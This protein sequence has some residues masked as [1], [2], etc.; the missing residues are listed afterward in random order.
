MIASA[1]LFQSSLLNGFGK[2]VGFDTQLVGCF[3]ARASSSQQIFGLG[4]HV[5]RYHVR[6]AFTAWSIERFDAAFPVELDGAFD[7]IG[8]NA[9]GFDNFTLP[10][11]TLLNELSRKPSKCRSVT[12]VMITDRVSAKEPGPLTVFLHN[13]DPVID[14]RSTIW[15]KCEQCLRYGTFLRS[16]LTTQEEGTFSFSTRRPSDNDRQ[17]GEYHQT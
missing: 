10:T 7:G 13:A 2:R 16:V 5:S 12:F 3:A 1:W 11:V 8:G 9:E 17:T 4:D 14:S 6:C 15:D